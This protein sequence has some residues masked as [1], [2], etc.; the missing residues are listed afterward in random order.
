MGLLVML[1]YPNV[2]MPLFN[3]FSSLSD[4]FFYGFGNKKGIV[5]FDTLL[6]LEHDKILA[7]LCHEFGHW[8][9]SHLWKNVFL[10][11]LTL[12][13]MSALFQKVMT[14]PAMFVAFG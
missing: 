10:V 3:K 8:V 11:S 6:H 13:L 1:I 2:I 4:A 9:Y 12:L 7:I 5:L 14:D